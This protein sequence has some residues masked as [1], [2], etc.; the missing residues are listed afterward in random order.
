MASG[1]EDDVPRSLQVC[2][3]CG[4]IF[5]IAGKLRCGRNKICE[6]Y[7]GAYEE[8]SHVMQVTS[9]RAAETMDVRGLEHAV[10]PGPGAHDNSSEESHAD[11]DVAEPPGK[12]L[13]TNGMGSDTQR[14]RLA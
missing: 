13:R 14:R 3:R 7:D 6:D 1:S 11:R 2:G 4:S 10:G 9:G 12:R 5:F 8:A